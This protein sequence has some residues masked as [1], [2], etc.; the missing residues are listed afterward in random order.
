MLASITPLG[1]RG[2]GASWRRTVTAYV[3]ASIVGGAAVGAL[4][5]ALGQLLH[6]Q[7]TRW[8][9]VGA[10]VLALV[11]A[12]LDLAGRLQNVRHQVDAQWM[13]RSRDWVS[14]VRFGILLGACAM[15]IV[16]SASVYVSWIIALMR[17]CP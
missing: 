10:G 13:T 14:G 8:T 6:V 16:T 5:G 9:L 15:T 1:E 17:A 12:A 4:L 11:A 7:D 2:R 3:M